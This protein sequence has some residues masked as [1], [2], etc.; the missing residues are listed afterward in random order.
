MLL[1]EKVVTPGPSLVKPPP[2]EI[3][4]ETS[5][6]EPSLPAVRVTPLSI[7]TSPAPAIDPIVS[8]LPTL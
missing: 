2:P 8:V 4:P 3:S 5:V 1:P 7:W 6:D